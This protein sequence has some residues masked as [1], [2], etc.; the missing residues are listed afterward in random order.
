MRKIDVSAYPI[1]VK[2]PSGEMTTLQY[3]MTEMLVGVLLHTSLR[4][5][6]QEVY[7]R[8]PLADKIKKAEGE[9]LLEEEE[10]NKLLSAVKTI[11]GFGMNDSEMVRRIID[12]KEVAVTEADKKS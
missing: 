9:L 7:N 1:E 5:T 6:G 11:Q 12:A 2:L 10:Y 3:D 4:L 8:M